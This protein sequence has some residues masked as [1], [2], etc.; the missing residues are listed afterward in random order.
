MDRLTR[1]CAGLIA[2]AVWVGFVAFLAFAFVIVPLFAVYFLWT[3]L[4]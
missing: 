2:A 3:E 4:R 1:W